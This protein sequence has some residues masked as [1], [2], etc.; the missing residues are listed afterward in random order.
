MEFTRRFFLGT[1]LAFAGRLAAFGEEAPRPNLKV[2]VISDV[3]LHPKPSWNVTTPEM[4]AKVL[5]WYRDQDVDAV[6]CSGDMTETGLASQLMLFA[7]T[8]YSVF[9]D[10]KG[11]DG[12]KVERIFVYGN[13]DVA[14]WTMSR[15][16]D[17]A[18][19]KREMI[20][21]DRAGHWERAFHEPFAHAFAKTVKGYTF[22]G[23]HWPIKEGM[24][25]YHFIGPGWPTMTA[26]A[27]LLASEAPKLD[28]NKPFFYVQHAHPAD[29]CYGSWAWGHDDGLSTRTLARFPN[30]IAVSGHSHYTLTDERSVW[31]GAFTSIGASSVA[32]SSLDYNFRDNANANNYGSRGSRAPSMARIPTGDGNQGMLF[33][34]Y[35]DHLRI[36]RC[37]FNWG[38]SLGDDWILPLGRNAAKPFTFADRAPARRAPEFPAD[39]KVEVRLETVKRK[40]KSA[41]VARVSFPYAAT[42]SGC[43]VFEYEVRA[44]LCEDD[45]DG[46]TFGTRRAL[47]PDFYLPPTRTGK[48]G[49][50]YF[51]LEDFPKGARFRFEVR[52]LECFGRKG[53]PILSDLWARQ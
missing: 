14:D 25:G 15:Y 7:Q 45:V 42:V 23:A 52:P 1:G 2:G 53:R 30:A 13:H 33:S 5:K 21:F 31:Q 4:F 47:A 50:I 46:L 40:D 44:I 27:E 51:P 20:C 29:T 32:Y 38:E 22:I 39:A 34:V 3:H 9:P 18:E 17:D 37:E 36:E 26:G 48:G 11:R 6:M 10:D 49:E 24:K 43:R 19:R 35:D 8:W 41:Q 28:P 16:K 12:R